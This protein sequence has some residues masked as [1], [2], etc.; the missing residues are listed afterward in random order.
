MRV[1]VTGG[2]GF[3]G[4]HIV[5]AYLARGDAVTV[6]DSLVTGTRERVPP[7][8][9]FHQ[10]D[11]RSS[12]FTELVQSWR[13]D[14]INHQAANASVTQSVAHPSIDAE[15]NV[16]GALRVLEAAVAAGTSTVV[17]A[18]SAAVYGAPTQLP[19][20]ETAPSWP[21]SPYGAAKA[22]V[23][24]YASVLSQINNI[25]ITCLRYANVYGPGAEAHTE[26]GVVPIFVAALRASQSP[27]IYG[28]GSATRDYIYVGDI[29][30]GNLLA[31]ERLQGFHILNLGTGAQTSVIALCDLLLARLG[32]PEPMY[33]APRRGEIQASALDASRAQELLGWRAE[34]PLAAGLDLTLAEDLARPQV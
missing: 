33:V 30:R 25:N 9:E 17:L 4:S 32:G 3:I 10:M 21:L 18:S 8:A 23:E 31:G 15:T 16:I 29:V 6:A 12:E 7:A 13:F 20:R 11:I 19:T 14:L 28:D 22:S 26:A 2:A 34:V 1:L 5:R 27:R 24:L